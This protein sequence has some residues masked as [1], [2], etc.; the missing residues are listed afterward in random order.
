MRRHVPTRDLITVIK[1]VYISVE[2]DELPEFWILVYGK[3]DTCFSYEKKT[4]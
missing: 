1:C 4:K 3:F 2:N